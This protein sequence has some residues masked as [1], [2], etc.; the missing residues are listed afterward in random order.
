MRP[1]IEMVQSLVRERSLPGLCTPTR[2]MAED[3]GR[4]IRKPGSPGSNSSP[5]CE[6]NGRISDV[7]GGRGRCGGS[8]PAQCSAGSANSRA[9]PPALTHSSTTSSSTG[10]KRSEEHTSELQSLMRHSYAVLLLKKKK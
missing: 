4:M 2:T 6:S 9:R 7:R 3:D 1:F 5:Q 8:S 10:V